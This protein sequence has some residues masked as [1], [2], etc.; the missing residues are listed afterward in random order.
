MLHIFYYGSHISG[1]GTETPVFEEISVKS[2]ENEK[3]N[4][5]GIGSP[6]GD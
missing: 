4:I 3:F 6:A 1:F 2:L 5:K